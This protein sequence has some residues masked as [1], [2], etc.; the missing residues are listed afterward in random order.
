MKIAF[1]FGQFPVISES[2]ILNQ[3][4]GVIDRGHQVDIYALQGPPPDQTTVHAD[5]ERY[6]LLER[7]YYPPNRPERHFLASPERLWLAVGQP[8]QTLPLLSEEC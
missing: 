8:A 7:T 2:F 4:T 6:R 3:I 5:V 1:I